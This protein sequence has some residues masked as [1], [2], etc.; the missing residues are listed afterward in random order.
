[1][2]PSSVLLPNFNALFDQFILTPRLQSCIS[3]IVLELR[4][5]NIAECYHAISLLQNASSRES[6]AKLFYEA[7][8]LPA[9]TH[10]N[11]LFNLAADHN[12]QIGGLLTNPASNA[13]NIDRA[14]LEL[15]QHLQETVKKL[16]ANAA[17]TAIHVHTINR[18]IKQGLL[19]LYQSYPRLHLLEIG[20]GSFDIKNHQAA[21]EAINLNTKASISTLLFHPWGKVSSVFIYE[22]LEKLPHSNSWCIQALA[23]LNLHFWIGLISIS[24]EALLTQLTD[25]SARN[26]VIQHERHAFL[27]FYNNRSEYVRNFF[28]E[29]LTSERQ[30]PQAIQ[31]INLRHEPAT[32]LS[33]PPPRQATSSR[34]YEFFSLSHFI[35]LA[36]IIGCLSYATTGFGLIVVTS[37]LDLIAQSAVC[38]IFLSLVL[39]TFLD[40]TF[41]EEQSTISTKTSTLDRTQIHVDFSP[42]MLCFS[43]YHTSSSTLSTL[44]ALPS[45]G[46]LPLDNKPRPFSS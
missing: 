19:Y 43:P 5:N 40:S 46:N 41:N 6:L 24:P 45:L 44:S 16:T 28:L 38:G 21:L 18:V 27:N 10:C 42:T 25:E 9:T 20:E 17:D 39:L 1:M 31:E 30:L 36:L 33:A 29:T 4:E 37:L 13:S 3:Q 12:K 11:P 7:K 23:V 14:R 34:N 2:A 15:I 26:D 22:L 32:L 8:H 35:L